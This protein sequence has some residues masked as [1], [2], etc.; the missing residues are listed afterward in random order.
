MLFLFDDEWKVMEKGRVMRKQ[1]KQKKKV[2][3]EKG[4]GQSGDGAAFTRGE[5]S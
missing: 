2:E 5:L 3:K 4:G 1:R